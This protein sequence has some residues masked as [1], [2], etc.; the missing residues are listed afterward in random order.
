MASSGKK[1]SG[2]EDPIE[3]RLTIRWDRNPEAHCLRSHAVTIELDGRPLRGVRR[4]D[5]S[6]DSGETLPRLTVEFLPRM[7]VLDGPA[8][9]VVTIEGRPILEGLVRVKATDE[10][11]DPD[12]RMQW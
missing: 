12:E 10:D 11:P 7:V 6:I 8:D 1:P 4:V 2:G 3:P 5:F 9:A